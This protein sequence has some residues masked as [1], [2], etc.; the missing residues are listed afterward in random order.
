LDLGSGERAIFRRNPL[1]GLLKHGAPGSREKLHAK[2]LIAMV[3]PVRI[4][5]L[6][7]AADGIFL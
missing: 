1:E 7:R 6:E 2:M 3:L 4:E 5:T